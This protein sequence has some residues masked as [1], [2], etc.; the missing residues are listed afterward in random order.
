MVDIRVAPLGSNP[1]EFLNL[2]DYL[3]Q[4]DPNFVRPLDFDLKMQL[5]PKK[6]PFF[7]HGE[8][9]MI[10][11][12]KNGRVVGRMTAQIDR[13]HLARYQDSTGFFGFFD[14]T[15]DPE[16]ASA[17]LREGERWLR[18][19]GMTRVMGPLSLSINEEMGCLVEGFDTPPYLMMPHHL[20][21]Q[22]ALI[23]GAGYTKT[24]DLYAWNYK[25]GPLN[26]RVK[27][28]MTDV[29]AMPEITVRPVSKKR[30]E[31]D[32]QIVVDIF[33]DAWGDNWGFVPFTR[34]EVKKMAEDFALILEPELTCL[35]FVNGEPAAMAITLPNINDW[36]AG[37]DGKLLPFG[38]AKLAWNLFAK[39]PQSVRMPLMGL[40][41]T[42]HGTATG[43]V[44]SMAVIARV[45]NYHVGRGTTKGEAS[46]ILE[47]NMPM[48]RM[49]E[50]FGG[51]P[52]KTY[53]VY[54]KLIG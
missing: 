48:R 43:A 11:A 31:D 53:R 49:I 2:A 47:D 12:R 23:E 4:S 14:T 21:Y 42:Y 17:L 28:A 44:L 10:L 1:R 15:N 51:K 13:E 35:V 50:T 5:D 26:S 29:L 52:Y 30:L 37:L 33:N 45:R 32:V 34:N 24:K 8:G 46:W 22:G 9:I 20:P 39:P 40:R 54:E 36:I 3:Y 38:W 16:V 25:V 6:N 41:K 27:K 19:K 7:E 18:S